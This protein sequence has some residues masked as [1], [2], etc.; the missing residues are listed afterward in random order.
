MGTHLRAPASREVRWKKPLDTP[1][2]MQNPSATLQ[3]VR[4]AY[5]TGKAT[6]LILRFALAQ[7]QELRQVGLQGLQLPYGCLERGAG[8]GSRRCA[9]RDP[10]DRVTPRIVVCAPQ[11]T[12]RAGVHVGLELLP[13]QDA[14][15]L[16]TCEVVV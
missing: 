3:V 4:T 12:L 16:H 10:H 5:S 9:G 2:G 14:Q 1:G 8:A 7:A 11:H 6:C 13:T 15:A